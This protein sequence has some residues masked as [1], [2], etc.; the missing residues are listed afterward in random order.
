MN[1]VY[2]QDGADEGCTCFLTCLFG[3]VHMASSVHTFSS[4]CAHYYLNNYLNNEYN[5]SFQIH[6][7]LQHYEESKP[8]PVLEGAAPLARDVSVLKNMFKLIDLFIGWEANES[9]KGTFGEQC[10]SRW[11][12]VNGGLIY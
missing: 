3:D 12:S 7:R 6:E 2:V 5:L 9:I 11:V 1:S 10:L 4:T 8:A